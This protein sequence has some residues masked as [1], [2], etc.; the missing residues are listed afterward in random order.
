VGA[1]SLMVVLIGLLGIYFTHKVAGPVFKM[2]R[3]L[4]QV[5]RGNLRV[6]ERLRRGD[7]LK[8]FFETFT[9]MVAGLREFG[10]TQLSQIEAALESLERGTKANAVTSLRRVRE[11]IR[12][13]IGE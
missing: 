1:L 12:A 11:A 10:K 6:E 13:A 9:Q 8:A 7:E 5:G 4:A 3:L 2:S